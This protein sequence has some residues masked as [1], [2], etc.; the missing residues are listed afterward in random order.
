M[1]KKFCIVLLLS[2]CSL[3]LLWCSRSERTAFVYPDG[4]DVESTWIIQSGFTSLEECRDFVDQQEWWIMFDYEC[5]SNCRV[6]KSLWWIY[7]CE[8]TLD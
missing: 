8:E 2:L 5:W 6:E 7:V 4:V 3:S 1:Y